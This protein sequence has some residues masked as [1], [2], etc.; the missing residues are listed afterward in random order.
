M[1]I[2]NVVFNLI[3]SLQLNLLHFFTFIRLNGFYSADI[4]SA[5]IVADPCF[6]HNPATREKIKVCVIF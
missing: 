1:F 5:Q 4:N 3:I 6:G 2:K